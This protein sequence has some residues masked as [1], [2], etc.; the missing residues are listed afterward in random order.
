MSVTG[1]IRTGWLAKWKLSASPA[2]LCRYLPISFPISPL[3]CPLN[4]PCWFTCQISITAISMVS[5]AF[6]KRASVVW[7]PVRHDGLSFMVL[8]ALGHGRHVL[9]TYEFPGCVKVDGVSD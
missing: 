2:R 6:Y 1:R 7:R 9:W 4:F 8:E 3:R 5:I